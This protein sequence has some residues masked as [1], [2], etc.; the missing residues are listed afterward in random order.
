M[1]LLTSE[2]QKI[3]ILLKKINAIFHKMLS[4]GFQNFRPIFFFKEF[5]LVATLFSYLDHLF[6]WIFASL[7]FGDKRVRVLVGPFLRSKLC[8]MREIP[9]GSKFHFYKCKTYF[10]QSI[11]KFCE[12]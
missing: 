9:M 4:L 6:A 5:T 7:T 10:S 1:A 2:L 12:T 8:G 3:G 11:H